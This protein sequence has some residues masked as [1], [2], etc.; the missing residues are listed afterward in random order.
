MTNNHSTIETSS[1]ADPVR[2]F[3]CPG[4]SFVLVTAGAHPSPHVVDRGDPT[5]G[6]TGDWL[7]PVLTDR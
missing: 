6:H 5:V 3:E 1:P 2:R 4:C 7:V